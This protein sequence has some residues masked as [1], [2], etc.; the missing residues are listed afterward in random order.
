MPRR[1]FRLALA[2]LTLAAATVVV[3]VVPGVQ[4]AQ[5]INIQT[6]WTVA[7]APTTE[8]H[9]GSL[10]KVNVTTDATHPIASA[11]IQLCRSGVDYSP[12]FTSEPAEDFKTGGANCPNAPVSTSGDYT[13]TNSEVGIFAPGPGGYTIPFYAG[14]GTIAWQDNHGVDQTLTCD[15]DH[16]CSLVTEVRGKDNAGDFRWIPFVQE[17]TYLTDDPIA[18]CGGKTAGALTAASSDRMLDSWVK[19]T[20][21]QCHSGVQIGAATLQSFAGEGSA[22]DSFSRG[23]VDLAYSAL[24]Y[25]ERSNFGRGTP[26]DVLTPRASTPVPVALNAVVLAVGN[27]VPGPGGSKVPYGEIRMTLDEVTRMVTAGFRLTTFDET[28]ILARNP[29]L[30]ATGVFPVIS[31]NIRLGG[32]AEAES[33]T[34]FLSNHIDT[35]R[36][37]LWRVPDYGGYGAERNLPRGVFTSYATASP[38]F[39]SILDTYSGRTVLNKSLKLIPRTEYGPAW[40]LT[41]LATARAL[42]MTPVT[43]ENAN[44]EFV[45]PTAESMAAAVPTM[46]TTADGRLVPKPDAVAPTSVDPSVTVQPYPLTFVE[47]AIAPTQPL[48]DI[49][50]KPRT[51]SQTVLSNWLDYVTTSGQSN[52]VTG[53]EPLTASLRDQAATRISTLGSV[54]NTCVAPASLG[55]I[56]TG[57]GGGSTAPPPSTSGARSS[58]SGTSSAPGASSGSSQPVIDAQLAAAT[59]A[60]PDFGGRADTGGTVMAILGLFAVFALLVV[61]AVATSGRM[62]LPGRKR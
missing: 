19:W 49:S 32:A 20:L 11:S 62:R 31:S 42:D 24:G 34:W 36:P 56:P 1:A 8:L 47:Y 15:P 43:I 9:D 26:A 27:G 14:A 61:S 54:P 52:L 16:P 41:D 55:P 48:V 28:S 58:A 59:A 40:V 4:G 33:T 3:A 35:L 30:R 5:A 18:G 12:S 39:S 7:A 10:I 44:G 38:S 60:L 46:Q 6:P 50:C 22:M 37:D 57:S 29:Q 21:D 51:E 53:L 45:G 17:V 23:D 13:I 25:D 2:V